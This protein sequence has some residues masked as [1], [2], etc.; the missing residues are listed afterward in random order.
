MRVS[1]L[2]WHFW[3][4]L[5][6]FSKCRLTFLITPSWV[7]G[8]ACIP[9]GCRVF[10]FALR[11]STSGNREQCKSSDS[12]TVFPENRSCSTLPRYSFP[13]LFLYFCWIALGSIW[14]EPCCCLSCS[15]GNT[16]DLYIP[17]LLTN[18]GYGSVYLIANLA[19]W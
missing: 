1:G 17:K 4:G 7:P 6:C 12:V 13:A 3:P 5:F 10:Q 19:G 8:P 11:C 16:S 18:L 9:G 14:R 2:V 15:C